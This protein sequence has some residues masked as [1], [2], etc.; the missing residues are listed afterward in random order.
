MRS[1]EQI[2]LWKRV[3][4]Y[5]RAG[6]RL[7]P[8]L[9]ACAKASTDKR[10]QKTISKIGTAIQAGE[11]LSS[12]CAHIPRTFKPFVIQM[13]VAGEASGTLATTLDRI[14]G[15]LERQQ[16][17]RRMLMSAALYPL[18]IALGTVGTTVFLSCFIFPRIL[19]ILQEFHTTLP[20]PTRILLWSSSFL[21][22]EWLVLILIGAVLA[23][24]V[25]STWR[26]ARVR[27]MRSW[28]FLRLPV[29]K[30]LIQLYILATLCTTCGSLLQSG[31]RLFQVFELVRNAIPHPVYQE[32]L[33]EVERTVLEGVAVSNALSSFPYLFP[34][35]TGMLI[36]AGEA[37]GTLR[38][39]FEHLG[40]HFEK[41]LELYT[42]QLSILIEPI[43][44]VVVGVGVG[45][46]AL[47]IVLPM[48]SITQGIT[49]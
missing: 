16:A 23:S 13:L 15:T 46:I 34:V 9:D 12:G 35:P 43:L 19:P 24:C 36:E 39:S 42:K 26:I 45:F 17:L 40:H 37:T 30:N 10:A 4:L 8:A 5:L 28:L 48:Y 32:A 7:V 25:A 49:Q 38:E 33:T 1:T 44:M 47:A 18:I 11:P 21:S 29:V 6:I 2:L 20:L 22:H 14:A 31:L 41:E 3:A 27:Y